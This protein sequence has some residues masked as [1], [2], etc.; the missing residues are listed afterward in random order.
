MKKEERN[1][2]KVERNMES[3]PHEERTVNDYDHQKKTTQNKNKTHE[4]L[5]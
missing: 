2:E 1:T 3:S 4:F 5:H